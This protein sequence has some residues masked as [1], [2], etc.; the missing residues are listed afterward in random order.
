MTAQTLFQWSRV[1]LNLPG[2]R[3]YDPSVSWISKI[4]ADDMM[5]CVLFTFVDDE[6]IVGATKELAW[7]ASHRLTQIQSYLGIQDAARKVGLCLQQP[8]AWAGAVVHAVPGED[9][10]VLTSEEK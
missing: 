2:S 1:R 4:R 5:A 3:D 10:F 7:Q 8:R 6:R 9:F